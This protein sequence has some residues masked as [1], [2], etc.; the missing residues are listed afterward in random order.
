MI[1]F[2][3]NYWRNYRFFCPTYFIFFLI[4]YNIYLNLL[5]DKQVFLIIKLH[6]NFHVERE[7]CRFDYNVCFLIPIDELGMYRL[8]CVMFFI[9]PCTSLWPGIRTRYR[10]KVLI[11]KQLFG[12]WFVFVIEKNPGK[13]VDTKGK[14]A[15]TMV[16]F[17]FN[18]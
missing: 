17:F 8:D 13:N 4:L 1:L 16:T 11:S 12:F 18:L 9:C 6:F 15:E 3:I 2:R 7:V 10:S 5:Y 14:C